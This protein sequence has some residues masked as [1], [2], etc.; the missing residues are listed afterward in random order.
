MGTAKRIGLI[1]YAIV[2]LVS[3]GLL[4]ALWFAWEPLMAFT[5][6]VAGVPWFATVELVLLG[7][8]A[9]GLIALLIW[10]VT[11]R[12][13]QPD[14]IVPQD[15][16]SIAI[17]QDALQSTVRHVIEAHRGLE[18]RAVKVKVVGKDRPLLFVSAKVDP[19]RNANLSALGATLQRE[20][21]A[22]LTA[23]SGYPVEEASI[24]FIGD[25][26]AVTPSF[27]RQA[28]NGR[29]FSADD[30]RAAHSA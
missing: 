15:E 13:M 11:A 26:E 24:T 1:V 28:T 29:G 21:I 17:T 22:S 18:A 12:K 3:I 27:T 10:A 5:G 8:T 7:I 23:F 9:V 2:G 4:A 30:A 16:G 20:T 6:W 25:A 19:G 14:L